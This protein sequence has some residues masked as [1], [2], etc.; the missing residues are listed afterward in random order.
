MDIE[1]I[2]A[3]P[4]GQ[5][6][7]AYIAARQRRDDAKSEFAK[8]QEPLLTLM[9]S[10]ENEA[11][12]RMLERDTDS[13]KSNEFG[14]VYASTDVSVT[15]KD[16]TAFGDWLRETDEWELADIRPAKKAIQDYAERT[17]GDLPPGV[18][19]SIKIT[20]RFRA[21]SNK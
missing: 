18:N 15:T 20:A 10:L 19:M 21:P 13:F 16:K 8:S 4:D 2:K 17:G 5:L 6:I 14:T 9:Q 11:Q 7:R 1:K 12:R 3:L